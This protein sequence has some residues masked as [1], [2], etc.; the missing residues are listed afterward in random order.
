MV[1]IRLR[2][3][4]KKGYPVYRLVATDIRSPRNGGYIEALGQYNPNQNPVVLTLK[5]NR[6]EHWLKK[7]AKPTDTV[8]TILQR[9]GF[10][11]RW[12]LTRQ[13]KDENVVK[14]VL[15]R[16]Q[17]QQAEKGKREADRR[18]RRAERKKK[19]ASEAATTP[20]AAPAAPSVAP[21]AAAPEAPAAS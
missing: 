7:G 21:A 6:I 15:E 20:V 10:W 5:E 18:A 19:A 11:L 8:R 14:S 13:G 4:G 16:W 3:E 2:R 17:M 12:T 9:N 1:K